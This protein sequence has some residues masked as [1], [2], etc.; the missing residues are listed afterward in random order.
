M[1]GTI[2][3]N[4]AIKPLETLFEF[5]YSLM[6][7]FFGAPIVCLVSLS[8]AVNL[9]CLPLYKRA[10]AIREEEHKKQ[11]RLAR[12][13]DHIKKTFK[14]DERYMMLTTYYRQNNYK[15]IH[16]LK[17]SVSLVLQIPFFTAAYPLTFCSVASSYTV[18]YPILSC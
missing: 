16:T 15:T 9:L 8:L 11:L 17:S 3:Y 14:G 10:D 4:L 18:I 7:R 5:I 6:N 2:L 13:T 1:I 12:W